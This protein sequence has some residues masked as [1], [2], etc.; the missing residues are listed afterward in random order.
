MWRMGL[1][2]WVLNSYERKETAKVLE[3]IRI[4]RAYMLEQV[5]QL[6]GESLNQ[7]IYEYGQ[8][9][10]VVDFLAADAPDLN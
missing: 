6:Q 7:F 3:Q 2:I 10:E 4:Q 5:N 8:W 1:G 9:T